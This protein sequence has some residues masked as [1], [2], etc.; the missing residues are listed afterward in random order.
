MPESGLAPAIVRNS[1]LVPRRAEFAP[2]G[3]VAVGALGVEQGWGRADIAA[4][5]AP[6]RFP[7][8][9]RR[10]YELAW[11]SLQGDWARYLLSGSAAE[12]EIGPVRVGLRYEG[13]RVDEPE[14]VREE[15]LCTQSS[16]DPI[17]AAL[18]SAGPSRR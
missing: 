1:E 18:H 13:A 2:G 17:G 3:P 14:V 7:R 12:G 15:P 11:N 9:G 16:I 10:G 5:P 8:P 4:E 6:P